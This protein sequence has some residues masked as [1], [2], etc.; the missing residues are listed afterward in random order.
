MNRTGL[1]RDGDDDGVRW[2]AVRHADDHI[3]IVATL[4]RQDRTKPKTWNDFHL[5]GVAG[6]GKIL[7]LPAR[8]AID[9]MGIGYVGCVMWL[10]TFSW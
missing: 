8:L 5:S 9:L 3:H 1:A 7:N 6:S 2:V 4:A 10:I